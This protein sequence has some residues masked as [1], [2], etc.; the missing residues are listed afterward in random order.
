LPANDSLSR[1]DVAGTDDPYENEDNDNDAMTANGSVEGIR[2]ERR[3][4]EEK[5]EEISRTYESVSARMRVC[6]D[7]HINLQ[8]YHSFGEAVCAACIALNPED[9]TL[10]S[11]T[12]KNLAQSIFSPR[13]MSQL[14]KLS[15]HYQ[16]TRRHCRSVPSAY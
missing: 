13:A 2:N 4:K 6:G 3:E 12:G 9:Y 11:K 1:P 10:I 5:E 7:P 15:F 14:T 16:P 8:M